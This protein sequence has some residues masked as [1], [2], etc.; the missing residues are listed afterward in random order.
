M[1]DGINGDHI[2]VAPPFIITENEI[3]VCVDVL[4]KG[5][6]AAAHDLEK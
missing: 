1:V 5:I 3:D 2:M 6:T 4:E